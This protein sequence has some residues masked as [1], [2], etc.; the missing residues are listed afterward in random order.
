MYVPAT[1][2][3]DVPVHWSAD[4][5]GKTAEIAIIPRTVPEA[6]P[7]DTDYHPATWDGTSGTGLLKV[8]P[9]GALVLPAGE[10]VIWGRVAD[11]DNRPVH[12]EG[13]LT[14]GPPTTP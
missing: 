6:E 12:R 9:G 13:T 1:S 7:E 4:M 10:Y 14:V 5:V 11:G 2:R 3:Q 8:G